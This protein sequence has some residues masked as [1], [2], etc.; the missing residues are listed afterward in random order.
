[1]LDYDKIR[2]R[3]QKM[4][5]LSHARARG[6]ENK[7]DPF[8]FSIHHTRASD[9]WATFQT[10]TAKNP[11]NSPQPPER[12]GRKPATLD[13]VFEVMWD[14]APEAEPEITT[15]VATAAVWLAERLATGPK[16][17]ADLTAEWCGGKAVQYPDGSVRWEGGRDGGGGEGRW[18]KDLNEARLALGV[19]VY[20]GPDLKLW[21]G[22]P[23]DDLQ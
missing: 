20:E 21:W 19:L 11:E 9:T 15:E 12:A 18:L 22:I 14:R 7:K 5:Q 17:I 6:I 16:C 2:A 23:E 10:D 3:H 8:S 13:E 1:V 4:A